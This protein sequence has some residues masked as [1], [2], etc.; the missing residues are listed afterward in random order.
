MPRAP[1]SES[2]GWAASMGGRL[3]VVLLLAAID[4]A[5]P[6][7]L[8]F[9]L[10][11]LW[12]WRHDGQ[13]GVFGFSGLEFSEAFLAG[14]FRFELLLDLLNR[15]DEL[16]ESAGPADIHG[17]SDHRLGDEGHTQ[18]HERHGD[19][20]DPRGHEVPED[21]ADSEG[22]C[23]GDENALGGQRNERS[24]N[25][26]HFSSLLV[27]AEFSGRRAKPAGEPGANYY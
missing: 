24:C 18:A 10:G 15:S 7:A 20:E 2:G 19:V 5:E 23:Q 12:E 3:K 8:R 21:G 9:V 11:L 1:R 22:D 16:A 25:V 6:G 13:T 14:I 17:A 26:I 27:E 4:R